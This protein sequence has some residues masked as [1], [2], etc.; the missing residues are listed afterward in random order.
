MVPKIPLSVTAGIV[1]QAA[2]FQKQVDVQLS[3]KQEELAGQLDIKM[4]IYFG[5]TSV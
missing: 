3:A 2:Q 5:M 1:D 4:I